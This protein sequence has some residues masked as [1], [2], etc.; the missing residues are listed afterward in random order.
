MNSVT[1]KLVMS[2]LL[3]PFSCEWESDVKHTHTHTLVAQLVFGPVHRCSPL[4][5]TGERRVGTKSHGSPKDPGL[6]RN[7]VFLSGATGHT[8]IHFEGSSRECILEGPTCPESLQYLI[9]IPDFH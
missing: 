3:S 1:P 8:A 2:S 7:M 9:G 5:H 4:R 6:L